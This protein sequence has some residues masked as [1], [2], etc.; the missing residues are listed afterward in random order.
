MIDSFKEKL[1]NTGELYLQVKV[2]PASSRTEFKELMQDGTLKISIAAIAENNKANN[3]LTR[4]LAK[5]F[6]VDKTDVLIISG[7]SS[8]NKLIKINK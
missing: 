5:Q 2:L 1:K 7:H 4:F 3:V 8:R 6:S